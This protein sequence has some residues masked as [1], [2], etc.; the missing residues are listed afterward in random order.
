MMLLALKPIRQSLDADP[1][2]GL[3]E[4]VAVEA[5]VLTNIEVRVLH[6]L[7]SSESPNYELMTRSHGTGF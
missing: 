5:L 3:S 1:F 4:R 7:H 6:R 2:A